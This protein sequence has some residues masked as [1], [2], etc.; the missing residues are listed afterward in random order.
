MKLSY[1]LHIHTALSPCASDDMTPNNIVNM[2][3]LKGLDVIAI[4]DH[5]T[6]DNC[7]ATIKAAEN[8]DILVIPGMELQTLEDVH[9]LCFFEKMEQAYQLQDIV[10]KNII[11]M[12]NNPSV[13]GNQYILNHE[14]E[15]I[16]ERKE[17]LLVSS[18]LTLDEAICSVNK[19]EGV[20]VPAHIDRG[21]N[22]LIVNLGFIPEDLNVSMME[23]SQNGDIDKLMKLYQNLN[24]Y[25]YITN[26]D[27]HYLGNI[28]EPVR[29]LEVENKS[30]KA[31]INA[32]KAGRVE[33]Q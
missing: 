11:K 21:H 23:I 25:Q 30:A 1:D 33:R 8:K 13:L 20:A 27:A 19:L 9:L 17:M 10:Q 22:S 4:T 2:S 32:L 7:E 28:A 31:I 12:D 26:S 6:V 15:V 3:M 16:G 5:N 24:Q 18:G 29:Y 14:D